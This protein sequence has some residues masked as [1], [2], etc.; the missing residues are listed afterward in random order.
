MLKHV[1]KPTALKQARVSKSLTSAEAARLIGVKPSRLSYIEK[2]QP[3]VKPRELVALADLYD[4]TAAHLSEWVGDE[5]LTFP[6]EQSKRH[7][8]QNERAHSRNRR[9]CYELFRLMKCQED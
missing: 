3:E 9:H 6:P 2:G 5:M 1:Y 8:A 7:G 4:L